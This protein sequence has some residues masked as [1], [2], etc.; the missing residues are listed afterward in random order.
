MPE[1]RSPRYMPPEDDFWRIDDLASDQ[2]RVMLL[3]SFI[4]QQGVERFLD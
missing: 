2:D 3:S 1:I 4:W